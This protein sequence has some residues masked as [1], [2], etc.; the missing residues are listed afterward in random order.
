LFLGI[1]GE[2]VGRVYEEIKGRPHYIIGRVIGGAN[3][4]GGSFGATRR[5]SVGTPAS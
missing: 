3:A 5:D 2:Y 4:G 1:I